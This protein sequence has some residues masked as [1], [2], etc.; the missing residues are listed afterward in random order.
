[1]QKLVRE[2]YVVQYEDPIK[3]AAGAFVTVSHRDEQFT[4]WL[5]CRAADG[6]EGWVHETVLSS[7]EPGAASLLESYEATELPVQAGD[8]VQILKE[9]DGYAWVRRGDGRH[10]WVPL[11]IFEEPV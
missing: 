6:R 1:M 9:F 10:G 8:P 11:T 2:T 4:H 3:V 5:W 7:C